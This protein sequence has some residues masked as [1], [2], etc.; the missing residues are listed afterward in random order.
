MNMK[1]ILLAIN[2]SRHGRFLCREKTNKL[3][4]MLYDNQHQYVLWTG[5]G[6]YIAKINFLRTLNRHNNLGS[7]GSGVSSHGS[8][9]ALPLSLRE[10]RAVEIC[11][12]E[13]VDSYHT[14][15]ELKRRAHTAVLQGDYR[16]LRVTHGLTVAS[17]FICLNWSC[18]HNSG[19]ASV[20]W[21]TT[22][23]VCHTRLPHL[24]WRLHLE[25]PNFT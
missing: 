25:R 21:Y 3:D 15:K 2:L 22:L 19:L 12:H 1:K 7:Y 18:T 16:Q 10:I 13:P 23:I 5:R 14:Q 8:M 9:R 4:C 24:K 6:Y 11:P 17:M 20:A